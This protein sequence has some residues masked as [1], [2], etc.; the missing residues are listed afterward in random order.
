M[1]A[2]ELV[3]IK[4]K[5]GPGFRQK[6]DGGDGARTEWAEMLEGR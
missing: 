1:Q 5:W 3:P 2:D 6:S 4:Q